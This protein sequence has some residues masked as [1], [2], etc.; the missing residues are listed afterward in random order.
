MLFDRYAS[1]V[2]IALGAA[3]FFYARTLT[4]SSTGA[5]IGPRELPLFLAVA[6]TITAVINLVSAVRAKSP[7]RKE[8]GL[9]YRQFLIILGL[10]LLYVFLLE[11]L[12]YVISTFL[13]LMAGFQTMEKGGYVKSALIAAAFSGGIYFVYVKVALG[14]LPG[15]P[16]VD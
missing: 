5:A 13:F 4:S 6:L 8:E 14:V 2:F 1:I 16:F 10:L 9:E 11:P 3:L 7:Q 12:G 15:L